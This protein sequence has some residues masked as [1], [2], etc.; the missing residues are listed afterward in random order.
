MTIFYCTLI[1]IILFLLVIEFYAHPLE[2]EDY[3]QFI[4][5][6]D[7]HIFVEVLIFVAICF[8][9]YTHLYMR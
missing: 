6:T 3:E 8:F 2:G 1:V 7:T 4:R 9:L 5:R